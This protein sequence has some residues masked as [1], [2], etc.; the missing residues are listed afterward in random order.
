MTTY[1]YVAELGMILVFLLL[2]HILSSLCN[3]KRRGFIFSCVVVFLIIFYNS[4][5]EWLCTVVLF[6]C[7]HWLM[8]VCA[9]LKRQLTSEA[10]RL[11]N[12]VSLKEKNTMLMFMNL[13]KT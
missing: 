9:K 13:W 10:D 1:K 2:V 6:V 3:H 8:H 11:E 7:L 4:I 12:L 5:V